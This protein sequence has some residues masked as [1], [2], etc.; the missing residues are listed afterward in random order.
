[1]PVSSPSEFVIEG[2]IAQLSE[3]TGVPIGKDDGL[4]PS[5]E[6]AG[7]EV[8]AGISVSIVYVNV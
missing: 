6:P 5:S 4:H 2:L 3:A 1:M 7:Q 8:K